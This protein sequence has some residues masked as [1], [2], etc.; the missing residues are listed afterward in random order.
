M[1]AEGGGGGQGGTYISWVIWEQAAGSKGAWELGGGLP[2]GTEE[3]SRHHSYMLMEE[4]HIPFARDEK[5]DPFLPSGNFLQVPE[6]RLALSKCWRG[7]DFLGDLT[8]RMLAMLGRV[9]RFYTLAN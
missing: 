7:L 2:L 8:F 5:N 9:G 1:K 3:A 4:P 6:G